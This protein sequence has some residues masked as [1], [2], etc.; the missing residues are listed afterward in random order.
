MKKLFLLGFV[1]FFSCNTK[2]KESNKYIIIIE[3][4]TRAILPGVDETERKI[5]S[6]YA[7][8]DLSAFDSAAANVYGIM[9]ADSILLDSLKNA[10]NEKYYFYYSHQI[11]DVKVL[12]STGI[13]VSS[14]IPD[15]VKRKVYSDYG[16]KPFE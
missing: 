4:S 9:V 7:K 11:K 12:N 10:M 3:T 2:S 1:F 5:D 13:D 6:I 16:I 15:S 14:N 8:D